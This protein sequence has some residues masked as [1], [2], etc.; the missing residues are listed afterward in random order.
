MK[1][2]VMAPSKRRLIDQVIELVVLILLAP[3]TNA[4]S[5]RC[6]SAMNRVKNYLRATMGRPRFKNLMTLYIHK[7]RL[8]GIDL[9]KVLN[10][11]V[12][13]SSNRHALFAKYTEADIMQSKG[14]EKRD[15]ATQTD[16]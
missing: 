12:N 5:E 1:I 2:R 13:K 7:K 8:D 6:F 15:F 9:V 3:A 4:E 14:A 11:F 16:I 10:T